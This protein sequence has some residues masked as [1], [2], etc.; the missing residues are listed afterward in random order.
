M[1]MPGFTADSAVYGNGIYR[2][3]EASAL[4]GGSVRPQAPCADPVCA[5]GCSAEC[6]DLP[7]HQRGACV[8][9]C[10]NECCNP[11]ACTTTS[12]RTCNVAT[13][14][15]CPGHGCTTTNSAC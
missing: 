1:N 12:S 15:C 8:R 4:E 6:S 3:T 7:L 14:T 9:A 13:T 11:P 2:M 5:A 10:R